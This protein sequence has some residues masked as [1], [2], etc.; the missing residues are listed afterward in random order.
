MYW[1]LEKWLTTVFF[2]P[3][4]HFTWKETLKICLC[5]RKKRPDTFDQVQMN[6]N[7][8]LPLRRM[9]GRLQSGQVR[10]SIWSPDCRRSKR[11]AQSTNLA[12]PVYSTQCSMG[13]GGRSYRR[14]NEGRRGKGSLCLILENKNNVNKTFGSFYEIIINTEIVNTCESAITF[15]SQTAYSFCSHSIL[16][17]TG[18]F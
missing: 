16:F 15:F 1:G 11:T 12:G 8:H 13:R 18:L 2:T 14:G 17:E 9:K 6:S 5:V 10:S 3:S 4:S 7:T